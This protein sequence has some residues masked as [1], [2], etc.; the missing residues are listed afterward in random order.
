MTE[1][2]CLYCVC[3]ECRKPVRKAHSYPNENPWRVKYSSY[4]RNKADWSDFCSE[5]CQVTWLTKQCV[6]CHRSDALV[7]SRID[8]KLYC[9]EAA[10]SRQTCYT[11]HL[12]L[13]AECEICHGLYDPTEINNMTRKVW[14]Q[15]RHSVCESCLLYLQKSLQ[16]HMPRRHGKEISRQAFQGI[17][18]FSSET[19]TVDEDECS[20]AGDTDHCASTI[21]LCVD[22]KSA[23]ENVIHNGILARQ[24]LCYRNTECSC[25]G[26]VYDESFQDEMEA[27][28]AV[29]AKLKWNKWETYLEVMHCLMQEVLKEAES[30]LLDLILF[31]LVS[32]VMSY[33]GG[34][35]PP[36]ERFPHEILSDVEVETRSTWITNEQLDAHL[37][38]Q[39]SAESYFLGKHMPS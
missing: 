10:Y 23:W 33:M 2:K 5:P 20:L 18:S 35:P 25:S 17:I 27:L 28:A 1:I 30:T 6:A 34:D 13:T 21:V 19:D 11:Y 3:S 31:P 12:G 15:R 32:E 26:D 16:T 9:S 14:G 22:C 36:S 38:Q 29:T 37:L 7:R 8:H 4:F 39:A 24:I